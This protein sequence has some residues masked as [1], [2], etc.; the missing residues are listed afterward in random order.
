[1]L[2]KTV[3]VALSCPIL[4]GDVGLTHCMEHQLVYDQMC[5]EGMEEV[6]VL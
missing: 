3:T 5:T 4:L 2:D 1:M 6:V